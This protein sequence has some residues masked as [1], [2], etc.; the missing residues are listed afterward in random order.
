MTREHSRRDVLRT[1]SLALLG[2]GAA[3][4]IAAAMERSAGRSMSGLFKGAYGDGA[5][6]LPPLPYGYDALAPL[7][8]EK[9][10]R[11]HHDRHH[12][13]YVRGLNS[14]LDKLEAAR[15]SNDFGSIK[16]L[17]RDLAFHGSGHVLHTLFWNSMSPDKPDV[18]D[19]LGEHLSKSFGS[20]DAARSQFAAATK[21]VE[22]S[23]WGILA[24]EPIADRL[25][26]FQAEKH[27]NLTMWG[28]VPLL[29]CDVW[30]HAYYLQYANNRG[31]WV[32]SFMKMANWPFAAACLEQARMHRA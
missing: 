15:K 32:D 5:Y 14:T 1:G 30:E 28:V 24:Y 9:T 19:S 31:E 22:A 12:A 6:T 13:G 17:S 3:G 20:V 29:V 27:Q 2:L 10:L 23:G 7:Y 26:I 18:P 4:S 8:E 16:A 25:L 21:A 11:I